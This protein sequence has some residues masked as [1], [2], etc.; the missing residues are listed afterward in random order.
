MVVA[1]GNLLL[2]QLQAGTTMIKAT[3]QARAVKVN[4]VILC[5]STIFILVDAGEGRT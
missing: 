5:L 1:E 3:A 4:M 2:I